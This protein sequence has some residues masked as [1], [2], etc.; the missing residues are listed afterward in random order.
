MA[1]KSNQQLLVQSKIIRTAA[2]V[3]FVHNIINADDD[4]RERAEI[5]V[6]AAVLAAES[7]GPL[8]S[9]S[10]LATVLSDCWAKAAA[11][12]P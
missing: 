1:A 6:S 9:P 4:L 12:S 7:T 11:S 5:D 3:L 2:T 8:P 10:A